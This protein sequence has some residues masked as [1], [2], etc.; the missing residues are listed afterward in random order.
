[1]YT[2]KYYIESEHLD[3]CFV[4]LKGL[5]FIWYKGVFSKGIHLES[6]KY[7]KEPF[8]CPNKGIGPREMVF[9][10]KILNQLN[11]LTLIGDWT[12]YQLC[13]EN[14]IKESELIRPTKRAKERVRVSVDFIGICKPR[15]VLRGWWNRDK[16]SFE[17]ICIEGLIKNSEFQGSRIRIPL[18]EIH[19]NSLL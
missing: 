2:P 18:R 19:W 3:G 8:H 11:D 16:F 13:F 15:V 14:P 10:T 12:R 5:E 1:M 4:K 17:T 9:P 6:G 7:Y